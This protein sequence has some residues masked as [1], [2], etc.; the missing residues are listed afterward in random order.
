MVARRP[1]WVRRQEGTRPV[2]TQGVAAGCSPPLWARP[3]MSPPADMLDCVER[4]EMPRLTPAQQVW[5]GVFHT[6]Q[7]P[8]L[9]GKKVRALVEELADER[10]REAVLLRFGFYGRRMSLVRVGARLPRADGGMGVSGEAARLVL[11]LALR[12]LRH[13]SMR[14]L[15]EKAKI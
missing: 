7:A 14:H 5:M 3:A 9:C 15:W 6:R 8:R 1:L 13:P 12:R 2:H 10:E 11:R 4:V